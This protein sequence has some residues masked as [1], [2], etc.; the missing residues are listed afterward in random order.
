MGR[1]VAL[2]VVS[3]TGLG[4]AA[5]ERFLREVKAAG[6]LQHPNVVT[7]YDV[8]AQGDAFYIA[9]E[10]ARA[11]HF[12]HE[13]GILHRDLK[14]E[15]VVFDDRGEPR[16][17]DFGIAKIVEGPAAGSL[18]ASGALIG[19]PAY[20]SPEQATGDTASIGPPADV[21]AL[22]AILH[23]LVTGRRPFDAPNLV[24]MLIEISQGELPPFVRLDGARPGAAVKAVVHRALAKAPRDR[25]PTALA[26]AVACRAVAP[27]PASPPRASGDRRVLAIAAGASAVF[28][29]AGFG[30]LLLARGGAAGDSPPPGPAAVVLSRTVSAPPPRPAGPSAAELVA[31]AQQKFR[32]K[33]YA[34]AR[35]LLDRAIEREPES[36]AAWAWRSLSRWRSQDIA[37][38]SVD[39]ERAIRLDPLL[40]AAWLA[41][42]HVRA[43]THDYDG[44][45][46]DA[47]QAIGLDRKLALAYQLR[48]W[49]RSHSKDRAEFEMALGD[50]RM[51]IDLDP[52]DVESYLHRAAHLRTLQ[53]VPGELADYGRV[54]A[55]EPDNMIALRRR[56][57][58]TMTSNPDAALADFDHALRV[59]PG[60][61]PSLVARATLRERR[62][63]VPGALADLETLVA[64]HPDS[65]NAAPA[66]RQI[67]RLSGRP[68]R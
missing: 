2:K 14:P 19:T 35:A 32:T 45:A 57:L 11:V 67:A 9:M 53:D 1:E 42:A 54:L 51:A 38:A 25:F 37:G 60:D 26:L 6:Q 24:E 34:G 55:I 48:G 41:R 63:D 49:A 31:L 68:S 29:A 17:V 56:G 22:G 27:P 5:T 50:L 23:E 7:T 61:E 12:A 52:E 58:V 40:A 20:M 15:N 64:T 13:R 65:A 18:S 10:L 62:G 21:W 59:T 47:G 43:A 28:V 30:A 66:R 46:A 8:G 3:R 39:A 44:A 16:L 4:K 36:A 33:D